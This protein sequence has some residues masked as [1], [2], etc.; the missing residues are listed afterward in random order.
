MIEEFKTQ[1]STILHLMVDPIVENAIISINLEGEQWRININ[2]EQNELLVGYRG[3]T[4]KSIQHVTRVL[5][6]KAFPNDRTHF[7]IDVGE[8]KKSR[9][10]IIN[11]KISTIAQREVLEGGKTVI[12]LGLSSYERLIIHKL[13]AETSGIET[14]S[15]GEGDERN[16]IIRPTSGDISTM[17]G[18]ENALVINI[19]NLEVTLPDQN[20]NE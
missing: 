1:L 7:L 16:L 6:H 20:S 12:L 15:V 17:G 8:Y 5:V 18:M 2:S 19:K 10:H 9:E 13:I 14:Q 3:E 4:I 11:G